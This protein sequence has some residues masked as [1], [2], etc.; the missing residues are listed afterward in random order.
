M[1]PLSFFQLLKE[2]FA[3]QLAN[4]EHYINMILLFLN[5]VCILF[6]YLSLHNI[7]DSE[8]GLVHYLILQL[9]FNLNGGVF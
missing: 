9:Q 3:T 8:M 4:I 5:L 7:L 1:Q 2:F 6:L